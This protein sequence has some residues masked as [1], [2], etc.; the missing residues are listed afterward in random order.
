V[1]KFS[2]IS[3]A[4]NIIIIYGMDVIQFV[5]KKRKKDKRQAVIKIEFRNNI[6]STKVECL[7]TTYYLSENELT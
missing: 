5:K 6:L 2:V 1:L 3:I 7:W 4:T